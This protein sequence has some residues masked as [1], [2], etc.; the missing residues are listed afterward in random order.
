MV[1][2]G[3]ADQVPD[4]EPGDIIFVIAE[5][6]HPVFQ[7]SGAD[8]R[9]TVQVELIEALCGFSRVVI[10]HL[11]GRGI[12]ISYPQAKKG[13]LPPV[14]KVPG[15]GMWHKKGDSRGDLY[16]NI[17]IQYPTYEWLEQH[18]VLDRLREAL[19]KHQAVPE[20]EEIDEVEYDEDANTNDYG[21]PG[22]DDGEWE[23]DEED[24]GQPQCRQQ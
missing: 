10:K 2:E 6:D 16:L 17:D 8:L 7:R 1:L 13:S 11:D 20:P 19:P 15:E 14:L 5:Q 24:P 12:S 3:E 22:G 4:Q 9:A 21:E 23:D 18:N